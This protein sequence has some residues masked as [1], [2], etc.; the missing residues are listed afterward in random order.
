MKILKNIKFALVFLISLNTFASSN[1]DN[2]TTNKI[3][4]AELVDKMAADDDVASV[5]A[6]LAVLS[7]L[8]STKEEL[9]LKGPGYDIDYERTTEA[10]NAKV[11]N[12]KASFPEFYDLSKKERRDV[13][14]DVAKRSS[15]IKNTLICVIGG[16]S[17]VFTVCG[18]NAGSWALKKYAACMAAGGLIDIALEILSDGANTVE[19][20][21]EIAAE[22]RVCLRFALRITRQEA[23]NIASCIFTGLAGEFATCGTVYLLS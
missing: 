6:N 22:N 11:A 14:N 2:C 23:I 17:G 18:I 19:L 10:I 7:I 12:V 15:K 13:L 1:Y 20:P 21:E 8:E 4:K 3:K 9:D 16:T 5:V